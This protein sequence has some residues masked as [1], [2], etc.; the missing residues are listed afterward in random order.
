MNDIE[1]TFMSKVKF[2]IQLPIWNPS[3]R[4]KPRSIFAALQYDNNKLDP[5]NVKTTA[6]EAEKLGFDSLWVIDHL[7]KTSQNYQLECWTTMTW[8]ASI[9]Y[10]IRIG[11]L[12]L[13]PL[14]RHPTILAKM[15]S[16]L[17]L[18]SNGRLELGL[19]A[20]APMNKDESLPRGIKWRGPKTRLEILSETVQVL[21]KLWTEEEVSFD[22]K[23]FQLKNAFCLPKTVQK[24]HPP[25]MIAGTGEKRTLRIVAEYA[26]KSNFGLLPLEE[27]G[28]LVNI[29]RRHCELVGRDFDSVERTTELG[30]VIHPSREEYLMDMKRRFDAGVGVGSFD[31]WVR[32]AEELYV[33]G[34]PEMCVERIQSYVDLGANHFMFRFGDVPSLEGMRLFAK[35]VIP[36]I[37]P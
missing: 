19:G 25:I 4:P 6:L 30:L 7:S 11:S 16:T 36:N 9:T 28:R 10:K 31:A 17:D 37:H 2:G 20:C 1:L 34:T 35:E 3:Y 22:G 24:P 15:A 29:L 23:H 14:Y 12:V 32:S 8:L 33:A 26:D 18:L 5:A 21:K 13:C 27:F